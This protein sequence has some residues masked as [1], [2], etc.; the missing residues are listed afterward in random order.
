MARPAK[1]QGEAY[2][3]GFLSRVPENAAIVVRAAAWGA[4]ALPRAALT[5]PAGG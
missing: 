2:A 5:S 4:A 1:I 3:E